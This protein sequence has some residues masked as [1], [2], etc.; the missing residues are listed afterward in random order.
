MKAKLAVAL[1]L[2]LGTTVAFAAEANLF[3]RESLKAG[4]R[5]V[6]AEQQKAQLDR[7]GFPQYPN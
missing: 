6:Q 2:A 4:E 5:V 1:A 3:D 7:Q